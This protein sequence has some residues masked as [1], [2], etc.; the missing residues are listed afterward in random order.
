MTSVSNFPSTR[1]LVD[2][3]ELRAARALGQ[4]FLIDSNITSK[5]ARTAAIKDGE[6]VIE[7]GP[8]PA[9]LTRELLTTD[10]ASITAIELDKRCLPLL[11]EFVNV[12]DGKLK[13][14]HGDAMKIDVES[15][16]PAPRVI[17]ANL[18]YNVATPLLIGW[19][20]MIGENPES[21]NRMTLMFQKEVAERITAAPNTKSYG[22][23]SIITQWLCDVE[24]NFEVP[25]SA[26]LPAP[27]VTSA[28]V[29][30][31][32]R[33]KPLHDA[34][35]ATLEK[36]VAAAFNQRRK[37]LRQSL[38]AFGGETFLEAVGIDPT[39][40]AETLSV[41]EFCALSRHYQKSA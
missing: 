34:D 35:F 19:L 6:H 30:L 21:I 27:K 41:E 9:S 25:P 40:R 11:Q 31:H 2:K 20:K 5:I 15:E 24:Y 22:R 36:V 28:I 39:R 33:P 8:G 17:V 23:L 18:P 37:M 7:V 26:F 16:V 4:N 32:A 38:K 10:A 12:S 29:T 14:M 13:I 3:Y 1:A